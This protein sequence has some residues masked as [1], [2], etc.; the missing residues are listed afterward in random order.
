M[1]EKIAH[2]GFIQGIITRMATNSFLLKGWSITIV[3]AIFAL[4]AKDTDK[5]FLVLAYFPVLMFWWLDAFFLH[6]EKLYRKLYE[7]VAANKVSSSEFTLKVDFLNSDVE[8]LACC[9]VSKTLLPFYGILAFL[10]ILVN[11]F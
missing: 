2:L 6:L 8:S 3:A 11:Y 1:E 7:Q 9:V 4:S 5:H 10:I